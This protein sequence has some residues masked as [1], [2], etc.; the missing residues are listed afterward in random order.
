MELKT[1]Y[2]KSILS[3]YAGETLAV[4]R[5]EH[6]ET[7]LKI[8]FDSYTC[9]YL[10]CRDGTMKVYISDLNDNVSRYGTIELDGIDR[11]EIYDSFDM[12]MVYIYRYNECIELIFRGEKV[13]KDIQKNCESNWHDDSQLKQ[14]K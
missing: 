13:K 10:Y 7:C 12:L 14:Q 1:E 9:D 3:K 6:N 11:I 8:I 2:L 4:G 5:I